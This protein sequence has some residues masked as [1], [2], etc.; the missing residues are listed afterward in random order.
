MQWHS[1]QP[2]GCLT[3]PEIQPQSR[4]KVLH[5]WSLYVLPVIAWVPSVLW[6]PPASQICAGR[7]VKWPEVGVLWA[8]VSG[9]N[10]GR[11]RGDIDEDMG[12][13]TLGLMQGKCIWVVD[14]QCGGWAV[15]LHDSISLL[16]LIASCTTLPQYRLNA[17]CVA[18]INGNLPLP[19]AECSPFC[20]HHRGIREGSTCTATSVPNHTAVPIPSGSCPHNEVAANRCS[21]RDVLLWRDRLQLL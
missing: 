13:T 16:H 4:P 14:D 10:W 21:S 18:Y 7:Y 9:K 1:W 8:W 11:G 6:F 17:N 19:L 3:V 12:S 15:S 20:P 2:H 5:V